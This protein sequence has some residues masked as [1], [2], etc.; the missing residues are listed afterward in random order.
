MRIPAPARRLAP[1]PALAAVAL[2]AAC[3]AQVEQSADAGPATTVQRCGEPVEYTVPQRVVAYEGGSA[4][5]LFALGLTDHV[6]GYVMPPAN[7]P[8]SESPWAAEYEQVELLSQDLLNRELVVDA[9]ADLVVA[10]WGSGFSDE[11]G[12]TPEILDGLGIQSFMHAESCYGYP[13]FP[14]RHTPFEGLYTDL[15]RLGQIFGV[16]ERA[17]DLVADYRAR[18]AAVEEQAPAGDPV[19][20]FLYDSGTDKPF[21]AGAQVPPNDI[22][23]AAGGE[24]A[25]GGLDERWTEVTWEAVVEAQPEVVVI[26]DYGDQPA[27]DKIR[28]LQ[29]NPVTADLP[30]VRDDAFFV[31]DYNEGIS[32]PRNIDGVEKFGAYLREHAAQN[33]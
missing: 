32:G 9:E 27:Q 10:G 3:G 18:V 30:A 19:P 24:N 8:V 22:I 29:E 16:E 28:F 11:R 6:L 23:R 2:L 25:F 5:K 14:E 13:G 33:P 26:L 20:V 7:P 31:L 15:E 12:I 1:L 4:D 17:T 21:T